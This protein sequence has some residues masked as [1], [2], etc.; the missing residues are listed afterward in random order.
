M[1]TEEESVSSWD[2][3]WT[4]LD[5]SWLDVFSSYF[6]NPW[7]LKTNFLEKIDNTSLNVY[8]QN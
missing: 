8:I 4:F 1:F 2:T 5:T 6:E 7:F 3:V